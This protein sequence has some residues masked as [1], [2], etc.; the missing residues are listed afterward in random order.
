MD[1]YR[2]VG[3]IWRGGVWRPLVRGDTLSA[4]HRALNA[5]LP[6]GLPS[7]HAALTGGHQPDWNPE[8]RP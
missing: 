5:A 2:W 6:P 4:A 7:T 1:A 8:K 3:W